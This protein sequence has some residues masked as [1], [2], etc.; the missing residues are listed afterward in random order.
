MNRIAEAKC[1]IDLAVE[2]A[3][4]SARAGYT[5]PEILELMLTQQKALEELNK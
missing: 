3:K 5:D 1:F 4:K 2:K